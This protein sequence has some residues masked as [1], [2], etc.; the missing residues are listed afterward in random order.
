MKNKWILIFSCLLI[1]G[2]FST[3]FLLK[4]HDRHENKA[5][6]TESKTSYW[7]CPMHPQIHAEHAGECPICHMKLV[8]VKGRVDAQVS[9]NRLNLIGVQKEEVERM[10]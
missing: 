5:A 6:E 9:T 3:K 1:V 10:T 2:L 4:S 7:T 8:Q